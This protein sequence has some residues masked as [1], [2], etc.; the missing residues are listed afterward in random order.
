MLLDFGDWLL[1]VGGFGLAWLCGCVAGFLGLVTS[2]G[3]V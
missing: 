2:V 3:L 1:G